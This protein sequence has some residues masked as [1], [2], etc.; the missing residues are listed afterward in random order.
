MSVLST[1]LPVGLL[2]LNRCPICGIGRPGL[3]LCTPGSFWLSIMR[4][5]WPSAARPAG[6]RTSA[7][8][9]RNVSDSELKAVDHSSVAVPLSS[10]NLSTL[11]VWLTTKFVPETDWN[12][13]ASDTYRL[14]WPSKATPRGPFR[15]DTTGVMFT[16]GAVAP[17]A[18]AV[19]L[20]ASARPVPRT[21]AS[22]DL[23]NRR[24]IRSPLSALIA[25]IDAQRELLGGS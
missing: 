20:P 17:L 18:K 9:P 10:E 14:P 21:V 4:I 15:P 11:P 16:V 3:T 1:T 13:P 5:R 19:L 22:R 7:P 8:P 12:T 23:E 6:P 2:R 25:S 24:L